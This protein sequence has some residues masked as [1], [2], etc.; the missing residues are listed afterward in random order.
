M[1]VFV[2]TK[3]ICIAV[4]LI[5]CFALSTSC[6]GRSEYPIYVNDISLYAETV[7]GSDYFKVA[8]TS[9]TEILSFSYYNNWN[10]DFDTYLELC[11][12]NK[13]DLLECLQSLAPSKFDS[14]GEAGY[15]QDE[16]FVETPNPYNSSYT[17]LI[18]M[19]FRTYR[20]DA[21]YTGYYT[22]SSELLFLK[23]N[24]G[25]ISYSIEDLKIL[26]FATQGTFSF[27]D[28]LGAE[29]YTPKYFEYFNIPI[30]EN[31]KRM[32]EITI[33]SQN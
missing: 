17:N 22:R 19:S 15:S 16:L 32:Y 6:Y 29:N 21:I 28:G 20:G 5:L 30:D 27:G 4:I 31:T 2:K 23:C 26:Q 24:F 9:S 13:E 7:A 1:I 12:E 11:F 33:P 3:K 25:I 14:N 18:N 8:L 10:E